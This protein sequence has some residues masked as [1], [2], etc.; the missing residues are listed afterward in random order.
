MLYFMIKVKHMTY[1]QSRLSS[2]NQIVVPAAIRRALN[3]SSG[4]TLYWQVTHVDDK[5]RAIAESAPTDWAKET[6]GLGSKLWKNVSIDTYINEL[7]NEWK[8][9]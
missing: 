6:S 9:R 7:R 1:I 3:I 2:K 4:D 8:P 5:P